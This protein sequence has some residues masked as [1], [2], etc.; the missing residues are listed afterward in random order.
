MAFLEGNSDE[1]GRIFLKYFILQ[2]LTESHGG[3][4]ISNLVVV[5]DPVTAIGEMI[6]LCHVSCLAPTPRH[7]LNDWLRAVNTADAK[8]PV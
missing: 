7:Q 3:L 4:I 5:W 8:G 2:V 6:P 1:A